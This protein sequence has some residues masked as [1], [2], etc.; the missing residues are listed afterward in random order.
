MARMDKVKFWLARAGLAL[1]CGW[2][3]V[4]PIPDNWAQDL[5]DTPIRGDKIIEFVNEWRVK[6]GRP[7]LQWFPLLDQA[8]ATHSAY[9]WDAKRGDISHDETNRNSK[10]FR[11]QTPGDRVKLLYPQAQF[12]GEVLGNDSGGNALEVIQNLFDAPFH[13]VGLLGNFKSAGAGAVWQPNIAEGAVKNS[14][15]LSRGVI[16]T[17]NM[18]DQADA[19]PANKFIVWPYAGQTEAPIDWYDFEI[20]SPVPLS[21]FRRLLGYPISLQ[22]PKFD[23]KLRN[24]K[25][26]VTD[27]T[28]RVTSSEKPQDGLTNYS[29]QENGLYQD[30]DYAIFVPYRPWQKNMLYNVSVTGLVDGVPFN[31]HWQ[32]STTGGAPLTARIAPNS[33]RTSFEPNEEFDVILSGGTGNYLADGGRTLSIGAEVYSDQK[34]SPY[35]YRRISNRQTRFRNLCNALRPCTLRLTFF[36]SASSVT[37][38]LT[39]NGN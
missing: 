18:V 26:T 12:T 1:I 22:A 34:G 4:A 10:Y 19:A 36:D 21:Y 14:E 24:V 38:N 27:S 15:I 29:S 32:F 28:G 33:N 39:L 25:F 30:R 31:A 17:V 9:L 23:Q 6:A 5:A 2:G 3:L 8:A 20:P 35:L 37:L 16:A 7:A 13:R 11:G